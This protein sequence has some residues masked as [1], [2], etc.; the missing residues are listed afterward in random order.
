[1]TNQNQKVNRN[2]ILNATRRRSLSPAAVICPADGQQSFLNSIKK[3]V[4]RV[5]P[6]KILGICACL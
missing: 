3:Q 2:N 5:K 4:K 1:M 6:D